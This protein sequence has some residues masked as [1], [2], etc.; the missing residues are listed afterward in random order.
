MTTQLKWA[1]SLSAGVH[2]ALLTGLPAAGRVAFDVERAPTSLEIVV[3]APPTRALPEPAPAAPEPAVA[4]SEE[5]EP[6]PQ[7][8]IAPERRGA[9]TEVLPEYLRNP[10]PVY[11]HLA[12]ERGEE[13]TV[14]LDV[15]VL[16]SGRCGALRVLESSGHILLDEA[17]VRAIQGWRFKPAARRGGPVAV[18]VEI[19][20]TF[21][22]IDATGG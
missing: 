4:A 7:T 5:P 3:V 20:V 17:A 22:L 16:P 2:A 9:L 8:L 15:E 12:R 19:L 11:P 6:E 13:G 21:R 18:R 14:V 1:V 10:A